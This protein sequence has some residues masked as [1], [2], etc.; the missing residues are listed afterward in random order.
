M[1]SFSEKVLSLDPLV[2]RISITTLQDILDRVENNQDQA[3]SLIIEQIYP[4]LTKI[5]LKE[6]KEIQL[7]IIELI[8]Y[9][10]PKPKKS[11]FLK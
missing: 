10:E 7:S 8:D 9:K 4:S 6:Y 3:I 1:T 2:K 5:E 11:K